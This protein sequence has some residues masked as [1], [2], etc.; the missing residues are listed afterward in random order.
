MN[1]NREFTKELAQRI[2]TQY[3]HVDFK[4][5]FADTLLEDRS[6]C[7]NRVI[8]VA[9]NEFK[10]ELTKKDA[11]KVLQYIQLNIKQFSESSG[12]YVGDRNID[13]VMFGEQEEEINYNNLNFVPSAKILYDE[14]FYT[15]SMKR[16]GNKGYITYNLEYIGVK[17]DLT[18][19]I[20]KSALTIY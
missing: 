8:T 16:Y 12:I 5:K 15:E 1:R 4:N 2:K 7:S 20:L 3:E 19:D 14:G 18:E 13:A 9:K 17:I 11:I 6:L 10:L